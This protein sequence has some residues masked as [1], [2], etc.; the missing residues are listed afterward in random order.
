MLYVRMNILKLPL[1][2]HMDLKWIKMDIQLK[3]KYIIN[4]HKSIVTNHYWTIYTVY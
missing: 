2:L 1:N 4:G 3:I